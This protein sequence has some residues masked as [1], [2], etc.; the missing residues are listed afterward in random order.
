MLLEIVSQLQ[1]AF[2]ISNT[3]IS[4]ARLKLTKKIKQKLSYIPSL[5]FCYLKIIHSRPRYHPKI[6]EDILKNAQK[7]VGLFQ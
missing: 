2:F 1:H 5:N 3:F 7:Q 4:N 6:T